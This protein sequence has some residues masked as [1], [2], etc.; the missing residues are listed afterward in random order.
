MRKKVVYIAH[1][2]AG[3][4]AANLAALLKIVRHINTSPKYA[5]VV[6]LVPYYA[7]VLTLDDNVPEERA[8][9]LANGQALIAREGI[10]DEVWMCGHTISPGMKQEAFAAFKRGIPVKAFDNLFKNL[11]VIKDE[12]TNQHRG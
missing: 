9:G 12:W 6:P 7:D 10:I 1:P 4:V 5:T 2:I 8:K 3:D 11:E